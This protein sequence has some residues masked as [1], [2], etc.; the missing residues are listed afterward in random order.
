[1]KIAS[2]IKHTQTDDTNLVSNGLT[3]KLGLD[4]NLLL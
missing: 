1:M 4:H 3:L 2:V